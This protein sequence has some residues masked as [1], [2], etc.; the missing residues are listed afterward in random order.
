MGSSA[1]VIVI[2]DAEAKGIRAIPPD[3]GQEQRPKRVNQS[4]TRTRLYSAN[5]AGFTGRWARSRTRA[6]AEPQIEGLAAG[7]QGLCFIASA[8]PVVRPLAPIGPAG[9]LPF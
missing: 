6:P 1:V 7:R 5:K 9:G 4:E 3:P 8:G 2:R